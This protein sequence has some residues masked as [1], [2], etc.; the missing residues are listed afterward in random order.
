[1]NNIKSENSLI[2]LT[3][4]AVNGKDVDLWVACSIIKHC[5]METDCFEPNLNQKVI[6]C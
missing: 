4:E 6:E 2:T 5:I 3:D 1:M